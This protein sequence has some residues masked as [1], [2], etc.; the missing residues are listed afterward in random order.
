MFSSVTLGSQSH[1]NFQYWL[2][3]KEVHVCSPGSAYKKKKK[4]KALC[5]EECSGSN[6]LQWHSDGTV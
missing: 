1:P 6:T 4:M 5:P 2:K 3:V